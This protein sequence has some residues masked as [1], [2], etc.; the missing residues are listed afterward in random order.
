MDAEKFAE[1]HK[2]EIMVLNDEYNNETDARVLGY[3]GCLVLIEL[4]EQSELSWSASEL[5]NEDEL[6]EKPSDASY[7]DDLLYFV[8]VDELSPKQ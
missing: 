6:F 5:S 1:M 2:G 3:S 4:A 7:K 8:S